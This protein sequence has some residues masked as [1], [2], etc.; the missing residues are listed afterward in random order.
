MEEYIGKVWG[1][2]VTKK[3][4]KLHEK[5]RVYFA[6]MSKSLHLFYHLMG[7]E[8]G[9]DLQIT[10]KRHINT[11]RTFL[12]KIS[13]LGQDFYLTWQD[14]KSVYLPAS[15]AFFPTLEQNKMLYFWLV[16]MVV[17]VDVHAGNVVKENQRAT[18]SLLKRYSGF[19]LF[20][21]EACSYLI[22]QYPEL[23]F[24]TSL[25][26]K[27]ITSNYPFPLWIYPASLFQQSQ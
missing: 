21:K 27:D 13:F 7:G 9:K 3:T 18:Q 23:L 1:K 8:K 15:C 20:Y 10:D 17:R 11:S 5:Q 24:V 22:E 26:P 19:K 2:Y 14:E 6:D 4:S 25:E 16:S 12:E